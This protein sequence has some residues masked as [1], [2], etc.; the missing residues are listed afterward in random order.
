MNKKLPTTDTEKSI[1]ELYSENPNLVTI[2][3][4]ANALKVSKD[5]LRRWEAKGKIT[6]IRTTSGYRLYD[7]KTLSKAAKSKS[8]AEVSKPEVV[9]KTIIPPFNQ[10]TPLI[11]EV[12]TAAH[13]FYEFA[14]L[15]PQIV[16][17]P[18]HQSN[19]KFDPVKKV[20]AS[21]QF[22]QSSLPWS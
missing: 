14:N 5:T 7:L 3:K 20:S 16:Q 11:P 19:T 18:S 22:S 13:S 17:L 12:K 4:A 10:Q 9:S 15:N 21:K 1:Q 6:S 8:N 2:Q